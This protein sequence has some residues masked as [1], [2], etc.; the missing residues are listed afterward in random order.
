MRN[1]ELF[2]SYET[3]VMRRVRFSAVLR[4]AAAEGDVSIFAHIW[5]RS[6]HSLGPDLV[7]A[8][9]G[10]TK[11]EQIRM[12]CAAWEPSLEDVRLVDAASAGSPRAM[13][14]ALKA[15]ARALDWALS[16]AVQKGNTRAVALCLN[17]GARDWGHSPLPAPRHCQRAINM[18]EKVWKVSAKCG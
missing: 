3:F 1:L 16:T 4:V 2:Q 9:A 5:N 12:M 17:R 10:A 7:K 15:G 18:C 14:H 13:R 11:N 8:C 6:P